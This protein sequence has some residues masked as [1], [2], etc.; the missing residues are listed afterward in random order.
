MFTIKTNQTLKTELGYFDAKKYAKTRNFIDGTV[1]MLSPYITHGVITIPE[2]VEM[3]LQKYS[4]DEAEKFL[5]E[6][7]RKEFFVQVQM[8]E[9]PRITDEAIRE[10]KTWITKKALL[11]SSLVEWS[12][13]TDW[14]NQCVHRLEKTWYLHN[15]Q[16]MRLASWCCHRAKLD[17]K[18]CADWTYY[19]FLDGE[20]A[21][22]HLSRQRVNST[23]SWKPYFMNEA[24]LQKY[25][26]WT[27]DENLRWSY[28]IIHA[29]MFN[30]WR[31]SM[32]RND[33]DVYTELKTD[34][35][36]ITERTIDHIV[37]TNITL[38]TPWRLHPDAI[39]ETCFVVL[40]TDF[41]TRHPWSKK[42]L[43]FVKSYCDACGIH[44]VKWS[45]DAI[46]K[47]CI[48]A[49]V[50]ITT[51]ER[52][53]PWYAEPQKVLSDW[54]N[55]LPYPFVNRTNRSELIPKFFKYRNRSKK[56]LKQLE[57]QTLSKWK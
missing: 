47:Q 9:G 55:I 10:D 39:T 5:M 20:L 37:S 30:E 19:H 13:N 43:Q 33:D 45:Y 26:P 34:L 12:T 1:S 46:L 31:V 51:D 41:L 4:I 49:W 35:S 24:N 28:E 38:L 25:R 44:L 29:R 16:R 11:P 40:D 3:V 8:F 18:K 32:Y 57:K 27:E 6:L 53:D 14:I 17:R 7:L 48:M 21:P 52:F 2:C 36:S 15:H 22:N 23:F 50:K 42:R 54:L 56:W